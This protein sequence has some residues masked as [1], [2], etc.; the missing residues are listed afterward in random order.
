MVSDEATVAVAVLGP[1]AVIT[2]AGSLAEP[3]GVLAKRFLALLALSGG[4]T[5]STMTIVDELWQDEPP[6]GARAALQTLVSRLRSFC[7]PGLIETSPSGYRLTCAAEQ[8]DLGRAAH[9]LATASATTSPAEARDTLREALGLWRGAVGDDL[10]DSELTAALKVRAATT[11]KALARLYAETLYSAQEFT[12]ALVI[13]RELRFEHP[14]DDTVTELTLRA[15]C[16]SGRPGEALAEYEAHRR[17]LRDE[18]GTT[19]STELVR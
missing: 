16:D 10:G 17:R 2:R 3:P 14:L 6:A 1:V 13:L 15:L 12:E 11:H 18:L 19:P 7:A 8:I 4:R 9:L 5:V